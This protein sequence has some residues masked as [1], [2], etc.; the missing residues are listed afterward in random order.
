ME[1]RKSSDTLST[2]SYEVF[3]GARDKIQTSTVSHAALLRT[4]WP[5]TLSQK[6]MI[7]LEVSGAAGTKFTTS[8]S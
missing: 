7:N 3:S 8:S 1:R 4:V 6:F 5:K 2:K